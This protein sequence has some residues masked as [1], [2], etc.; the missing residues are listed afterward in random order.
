M[1]ASYA[2]SLSLSPISPIFT[3]CITVLCPRSD[4]F[5]LGC[6]QLQFISSSGFLRMWRPVKLTLPARLL[7]VV[8]VLDF[9]SYNGP[10]VFVGVRGHT[11]MQIFNFCDPVKKTGINSLLTSSIALI[12]INS[13]VETN[14]ALQQNPRATDLPKLLISGLGGYNQSALSITNS[15]ISCF[16]D[17]NQVVMCYWSTSYNTRASIV[18]M[19]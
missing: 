9:C 1:L 3:H 7:L 15:W 14:L 8:T 12:W 4:P 11:C 5:L 2:V 19:L 18:S 17:T 6:P 16:V 13:A 10:P